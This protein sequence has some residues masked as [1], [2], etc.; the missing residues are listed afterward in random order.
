MINRITLLLFIGL[1]FLGCS[2]DNTPNYIDCK[3]FAY[4]GWQE[5]DTDCS[6]Y[7][8]YTLGD[9]TEGI[10]FGYGYGVTVD[11]YIHYY[12]TDNYLELGFKTGGGDGIDYTKTKDFQE[13]IDNGNNICVEYESVD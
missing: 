2:E 5:T 3:W 4:A 1:A 8:Q 9:T 11:R 12:K 6:N 7:R 13:Y 10:G